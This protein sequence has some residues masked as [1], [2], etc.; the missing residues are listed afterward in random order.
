[1]TG[2]KDQDIQQVTDFFKKKSQFLIMILNNVH[3]HNCCII[4]GSYIGYMFRLIT[5]SSSG[6]FSRLSHN[7]SCTHCDPSVFTSIKYIKSFQ[8]PKEV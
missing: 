8:F 1:M 4:Q 3:Q 7:V 5:P 6:L 2:D